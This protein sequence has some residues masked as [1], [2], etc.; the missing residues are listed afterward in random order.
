MNKKLLIFVIC[1]F[2]IIVILLFPLIFASDTNNPENITSLNYQ[3]T[4]ESLGD[5][6]FAQTS[7]LGFVNYKDEE[8]FKPINTTIIPYNKDGYDYSMTTAPYQLYFKSNSNWGD[9][10][11]FCVNE[12]GQQYCLIYQSSDYSY[13]DIYGSQDYIS[14]IQNSNVIINDSIFTYPNI[15]SGVNL[16]MTAYNG[17]LKE[18]YILSALPRTPAGYLG[19]NITLDFGGYIK[20]GNLN[21]SVDGINKGNSSFTTNNKIDFMLGNKTL[22]YL[23]KPY[24]Y[25]SNG[26]SI[27]LQYEVVNQGDQ[28]WFYVRT[29]YSWLN[30][31]SRVYPVYIDPSAGPSSPGTAVNLFATGGTITWSTPTYVQTSNNLDASA[32]SSSGTNPTT[33]YL[34]ATN[35]GFTIPSDATIDGIKVEI[36]KQCSQQDATRHT[37]DSEVKIVNEYGTVGTT[38]RPAG[39]YWP[40][41]DLYIS[42]GIGT[43][44]LWG[45]TW[46]PS[47]INDVDF[48][49]VIS[50]ALINFG[51]SVTAYIDHI[52]ITV[53]YTI[54][55]CDCPG[56]NQN[57]EID[58]ADYCLITS[59]CNLG[60]GTLSFTGSGW[61]K[62]DASITT[63]NMG[64]P[65]ANGILHI[66]DNCLITVN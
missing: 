16:T 51:G 10:V 53:Y 4:Q 59:T 42:H 34:K 45:E 55:T 2:A 28:I 46:T 35:F 13:R 50:A 48:G 30:D 32:Y 19:S 25:D 27:N 60:T 7:S 9:G 18:N 64:D 12:S 37:S 5:G 47:N 41:T 23:P 6:K 3:V 40:S 14:S 22:F 29:P 65:G 11:K 49:M 31:S 21:M 58:M 38:N 56:F 17:M 36:E 43:T 63:T 20:F 61:C 1:V 52:R 54:D 62:C 57:W 8:E 39:G 33:Y 24:A 44:D 26:S 66:N 15:H